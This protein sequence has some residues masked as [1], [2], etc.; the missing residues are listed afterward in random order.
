MEEYIIVVAGGAGKRMH[1]DVPKQ[2]LLLAGR[3]VLMHTLEALAPWGCLVLALPEQH[4]AL[5][6]QLCTQYHFTL[7]HQVVAGGA[8]RFFSVKNALQ[9]VPEGGLVAVHDGVR[10]LVSQATLQRL[11][12]AAKQHRAVVPVLPMSESVR[13]LLP[14]G[15]KAVE[16]SAYV[17][18][19]TPQVFESTLLKQ[20]YNQAYCPQFTD[21]ASVVETLGVAVALCEGNP[22]NIK[23][24]CPA[25]LQV[26]E[27]LL[28]GVKQA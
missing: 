16:R 8:E 14:Q 28:N 22:E 15:S 2:F 4:F 9:V 12:E 27:A 17:R 11:F 26:A 6:K 10:P 21:D 19:Q 1:T 7:P 3:P 20:A 5:W 13:Q 18:V 24:T 23:I 25:D